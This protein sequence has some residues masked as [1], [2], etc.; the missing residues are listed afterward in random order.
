MWIEFEMSWEASRKMYRQL[1]GKMTMYYR[2]TSEEYWIHSRR[3]PVFTWWQQTG[4]R[5][6][7]FTANSS[8]FWRKKRTHT[9][10]DWLSFGEWKGWHTVPTLLTRKKK[11][12]NNGRRNQFPL[13][14]TP[15]S[16]L[17]TPVPSFLAEHGS[18]QSNS[19]LFH[20]TT[21]CNGNITVFSW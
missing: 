1:N 7:D 17:F 5:E 4:I 18:R 16:D 15:S 8:S 19:S 2:F 11:E 13:I 10:Q 9:S 20:W 6:D 21:R 12:H 3:E 14:S